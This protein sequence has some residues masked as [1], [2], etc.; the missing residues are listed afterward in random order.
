MGQNLGRALQGIDQLD[1]ARQIVQQERVCRLPITAETLPA[2]RTGLEGVTTKPGGTATNRFLEFPY[3]VA[4]KTGS[5]GRDSR[6]RIRIR[7]RGGG[8]KRRYRVI[9][10]KR[11]KSDVPARVA[12]M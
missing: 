11:D 12:R 1:A 10:F 2:I 9:D 5:G 7:H 3:L 4:G 8:H 6:G